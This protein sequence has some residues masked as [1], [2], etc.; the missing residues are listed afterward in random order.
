MQT[1]GTKQLSGSASRIIST[2]NLP[3]YTYH[4]RP[5]SDGCGLINS[6]AMIKITH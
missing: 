2:I 5:C 6:M 3:A 4:K 1:F